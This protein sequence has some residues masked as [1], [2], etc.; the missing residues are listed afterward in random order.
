[1]FLRAARESSCVCMSPNLASNPHMQAIQ[2]ESHRRPR[3]PHLGH[4]ARP[5]ARP[6]PGPHPHRSLRRQLHRHLLPRGPLPRRAP[7]H[8][9]PGGRR[10]LS[11]LS[12]PASP[13]FASRRPRRMVRG[14][15]HLRDPRPRPGRPPGPRPGRPN[16]PAGR[17]RA[18]PGHDR[19]LPP[20]LHLRSPQ[21]GD[22]ILIHAG[23]GGTGL[24]LIQLAKRL[25]AH[26]ITTVSTPEKAA[27]AR[28]AGADD[29]IL[30]TEEDIATRVHEITRAA[31]ISR[32]ST[33]RWASPPSKPHSSACVRAAPWSSSAEPPAPC[34]PSTSSASPPSAPSTSPAP[35]S[36][37]TSPPAKT[38]WRAPT[39]SL[40]PRGKP[41]GTEAPH[42]PHLPA[43]GG[44]ASAHR[45]LESRATTGKLLLLP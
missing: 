27:L 23:A 32:S 22:T 21:P 31:A 45:D 26:V 25:G 10:E 5:R 13:G 38:S 29:V 6:R 4:P 28:E 33:I 9:G 3:S 40:L 30:Y 15:R 11:S 16:L 1:M 37:T 2:I 36:R 43:G 24:L 7:L 20:A 39:D 42:R 8:P 18:A 14:A 41:D 35:P 19:P 12:P 34:R 17:R 44:R